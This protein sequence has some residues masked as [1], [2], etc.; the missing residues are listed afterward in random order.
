MELADLL[1]P[2]APILP[3]LRNELVSLVQPWRLIQI[4]IILAV[5]AVAWL[6]HRW[7]YPRMDAWMRAQNLTTVR[8]RQLIVLRDRIRGIVFVILIW[9]IYLVMREVTWPSRSHLVGLAASLGAAWVGI[10]FLTRLVRNRPLRRIVRWAAWTFA[11]IAILGLL[12]DVE[13]MLDGIGF[14]IG[15]TRITAL[16]VVKA[17][18][19][20]VALLMFARLLSREAGARIARSE[21][22]SPS[23]Q[24]LTE[25]LLSLA[26][27]A[28][29][30]VI[31]LNAVGF[32]LTTLTVLSGAIG[33]GVGFGLQK[34]VSNLVSGLILL[35][36]KSIKPGDVIS[37][38]QTFGW[39]TELNARYVSV[40]T[41]DGKE[42]L[43]P[44]EDLITG[45]VV[46]WS[47]T[48]DLVRLDVDFGVSYEADP[49]LVRRIAVEAASSVARVSRDP[50]AVCHM[51][52]FGESSIDFVL[53]FWIIDPSGGLTNVRG[54]VLLALFDALKAE[55]VEIPFPQRVVHFKERPPEQ[56]LRD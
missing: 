8:A 10:G 25:K 46:N 4:G 27:Y 53:R 6:A 1:E 54:A 37:L 31:G 43:I 42:Y 23:M 22:L 15:E 49:H 16:L 24:V 19:V 20:I 47:Y 33:L 44:N 34:V 18:V 35:L 48:N 39:I 30:V 7:L 52:G 45:Q 11:T 5:F 36:D 40:V 41:R 51:T 32:D 2:L 3:I 17:A 12:P 56:A 28:G 50:K 9:A 38:G 13:D 26:L 29:V 55:N 14:T 21:D